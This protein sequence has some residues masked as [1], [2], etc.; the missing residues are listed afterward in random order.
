VKGR[1]CKWIYLI[2]F[3]LNLAVFGAFYLGRYKNQVE[4]SNLVRSQLFDGSNC[5]SPSC[6]TNIVCL[7][8]GRVFVSP[9]ATIWS[10]GVQI[11]LELGGSQF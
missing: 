8:A 3:D 6:F 7:C 11:Y 5:L 9:S 1:V 10:V 4:I 2:H